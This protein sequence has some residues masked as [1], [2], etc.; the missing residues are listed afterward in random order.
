MKKRSSKEIMRIFGELKALYQ[1]LDVY[2]SDESL[3]RQVDDFYRYDTEAIISAIAAIRRD[4]K[5]LPSPAEMLEY[6]DRANTTPPVEV[7]PDYHCDKCHGYGLLR[8]WSIYSG[9]RRD[10]DFDEIVEPAT[11]S[12]HAP[13]EQYKSAIARCDCLFGATCLGF[14]LYTGNGTRRAPNRH[15]DSVEFR[16]VSHHVQEVAAKMTVDFK[17]R[18]IPAEEDDIPF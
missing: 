14:P 9:F 2:S 17:Q 18:Q 10:S 8:V 13:G 11:S 6:V 7:P 4:C 16:P 5:K 15:D 1:S 3:R 12:H